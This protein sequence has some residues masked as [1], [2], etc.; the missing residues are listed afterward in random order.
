MH[1]GS[2]SCLDVVVAVGPP[3]FFQGGGQRKSGKSKTGMD[4]EK[5]KDQEDKECLQST[6]FKKKCSFAS[7]FFLYWLH[8]RPVVV[9]AVVVFVVIVVVVVVVCGF[10]GRA[11]F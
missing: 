9:T 5:Q 3:L 2:A 11:H 4:Q 10:C 7:H 6:P 8:R 1:K